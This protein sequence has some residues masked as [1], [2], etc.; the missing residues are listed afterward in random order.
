MDIE[1]VHSKTRESYNLASQKYHDLFHD[2]INEKEFD[3]NLLDQ[4]AGYFTKNSIVCDAGCGPSAHIGKYF[5]DK[6]I[7]ITGLDISDKCIELAGKYNPGMKFTIGDMINMP[8]GKETYDGIIS[9]YSVLHTP[10]QYVGI[11]F[12]EFHRVLKPGGLLLIAV[13]AGT[14]EGY[15]PEL[16]GIQTEIYFSLF[17]EMEIVGY[18]ESAGF[19]IEHIEKRNPYEFEINNER[20]FAIGRKN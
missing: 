7:Q 4:I 12:N 2:E 16:L 19:N 6:G 18:F 20:I 3:Q 17:S 5:Y 15:I 8:F 1:S 14:T 10:K 11:I 13:K 9:Y